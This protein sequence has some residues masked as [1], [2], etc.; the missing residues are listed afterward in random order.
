MKCVI[1]TI[2]RMLLT[3]IK[4]GM[5]LGGWVLFGV[6]AWQFRG[7]LLF[8]IDSLF[9]WKS[10]DAQWQQLVQARIANMR[11]VSWEDVRPLIVMLG[12]SQIEMGSWYDLFHGRFAIRNA[13]LSRAKIADVS[14]LANAISGMNPEMVVVMCGVN[15]LG[16]GCSVDAAAKDYGRLLE[17]IRGRMDGHRVLVLSIMPVARSRMADGS[18]EL[19]ASVSALNVRL[20]ELCDKIGVSYLDVTRNLSAKDALREDVTWDGLHLSPPGYRILAEAI[21]PT[22]L[23]MHEKLRK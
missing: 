16:T 20:N 8:K 21:D 3:A 15:D 9:P 2:P 22:L 4:V 14:R 18:T 1:T 6:L 17:N 7:R 5:C 19:N 10:Q 13:G 23:K 12:D 11:E